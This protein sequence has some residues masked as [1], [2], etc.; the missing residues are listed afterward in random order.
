MLAEVGFRSMLEAEDVRTLRRRTLS[1]E[2]K[3][4]WLQRFPLQAAG[5]EGTKPNRATWSDTSPLGMLTFVRSFKVP[6]C[7]G[8]Y[9]GAHGT[10]NERLDV[11]RVRPRV[12]YRS[13]GRKYKTNGTSSKH[14][15]SVTCKV[16]GTKP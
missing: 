16:E 6:M 1:H 12:D 10:A 9:L 5:A 13:V 8:K 4:R 2:T 7:L 15:G 3:E 11:S 14:M